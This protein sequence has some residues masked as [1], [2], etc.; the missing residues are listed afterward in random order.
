MAKV[1]ACWSPTFSPDGTK[2][3][4]VSNM[5]GVPQV[6]VMPAAGGFPEQITALDDPVDEVDWSPNGETLAFA[7]APGGGLNTQVY[8]VKPDGTGMRRLTDGGQDNNYIDR[9]T[10]DGQILA[11]SSNR[12]DPATTDSYFVDVAAGKMR[13][14]A[15]NKGVGGVNDVSRDN[16]FAVISRLMNR[17]DNNLFVIETASGKEAI[18]TSHE[19]PGSFGSACFTPDGRTIYFISNKDRDLLAFA[20]VRLNP[21]GRPGEIELISAREDAE[22]ASAVID[23]AGTTLALLWNVA[24]KSELAFYDVKTGKV[25]P[26]PPLPA[27]I[28]TEME[29]S[30][31]GSR[32]ALVATGANAPRDIHVLDMKSKRFAQVTQSPHAGI[33]LAGMTRPELV[34][35]KAHDGLDLSGW[36][37]RAKD[38]TG[39]G[40]IVLSFHG[41]PEGQER[42]GFNPTY[43]ALVRRGISVLAPNVRGSS[44]FGKRFVNLDNGALREDGVGDIKATVDYVVGE[45]VADPQRIGIMGGSYGGYMVMAGLAEYPE[46]FAAGANLFGVVNFETF[47][48]NTQPWMAAISKV[49]Y[50]NPETEAEMLRKLSPIHRVDRVRAPTIVLHGAND[51]NVPVI[52]AEQVVENLK[53]RSIPVEYVLFPDEGHGWRKTPNRIRATVRIVTWFDTHLKS[54]RTTAK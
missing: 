25:T 43:Q 41:G 12:R 50:G 9:W 16:R 1:G 40:P 47:F 32:L 54:D 5:S 45:K 42:P 36:L 6:Y 28:V 18:F 48:K 49:E 4:F 8:I 51:T 52:E 14:I 19:G 44:G 11:I 7:V 46:L 13:M 53:R 15:E 20:R 17:S 35:Y 39:P 27:E 24:G 21:Q 37:Y 34:R 23:E 26:G 31:D 22:A 33:D 38:V 2:V 3:A 30:N 29:F 10:D